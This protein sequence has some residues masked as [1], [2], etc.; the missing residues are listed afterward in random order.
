MRLRYLRWGS[1]NTRS[2]MLLHDLGDCAGVLSG[3][4]RR[5]ALECRVACLVARR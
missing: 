2:V 4:G 1:G 5:R 3:L